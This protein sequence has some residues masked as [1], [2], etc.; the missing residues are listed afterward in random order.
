MGCIQKLDI[1]SHPEISSS[2]SM[3]CSHCFDGMRYI[4]SDGMLS[5]HLFVGFL[6]MVCCV[7]LFKFQFGKQ[8]FDTMKHAVMFQQEIIL[9]EYFK[10]ESTWESMRVF[11]SQHDG[12]EGEMIEECKYGLHDGL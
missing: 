5:K 8:E 2:G 7:L 11:K 1:H 6:Y 3:G 12:K 9:V 4:C 10:F